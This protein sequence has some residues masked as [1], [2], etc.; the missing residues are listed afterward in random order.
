MVCN[1]TNLPASSITPIVITCTDF[2]II[3]DQRRPVSPSLPSP[4]QAGLCTEGR[5]EDLLIALEPEVASVYCHSLRLHE[6]VHEGSDRVSVYVP[7]RGEEARTGA[8]VEMVRGGWTECWLA[9]RG[10]KAVVE[11]WG[12]WLK[13]LLKRSTTKKFKD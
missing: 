12:Q 1:R 5:R 8:A 9:V 4:P 13:R 2:G 11:N 7:S 3:Q 6:L 10:K